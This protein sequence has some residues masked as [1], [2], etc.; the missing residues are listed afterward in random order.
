MRWT[1]SARA[2]CQ[3]QKTIAAVPLP[4]PPP[5]P[6]ELQPPFLQHQLHPAHRPPQLQGFREPLDSAGAGAP[7]ADAE[8][9]FGLTGDP[10]FMG[11]AGLG[12]LGLSAGSGLDGP[13]ASYQAGPQAS[14]RAAAGR[15]FE[16]ALAG[17]P[18]PF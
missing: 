11:A 13:R 8:D 15:A 17:P 1:S 16:W 12:D 18:G 3:S 10:E 5:L 9:F 7:R 14:R 4:L 6:R 2:C